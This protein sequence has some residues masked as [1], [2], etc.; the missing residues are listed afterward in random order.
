[1]TLLSVSFFAGCHSHTRDD[2]AATYEKARGDFLHGN[3]DVARQEAHKAQRDFPAGDWTSRFRLLEAEILTYQG[4]RPDVIAL[5][6]CDRAAYPAAGDTAI[7]RKVLCAQAHAGLGKGLQADQE[8]HDAHSLSDTTHSALIG[9]VLQT[10]AKVQLSRDHVHEA[11]DLYQQSLAAA[12]EQGNSFLEASDLLN[13]GYVAL[14]AEHY[15]EAVTLLNKAASFAASVQA[16]L[17]SEASLGN[18]GVAFFHLGDFEKALANF[19]QAEEEAKK[20]GTTSA[21]V[22]WLWDAGT[23]HYRLGNLEEAK[24][25]YEQSL[26]A[27]QAIDNLEEIA[28]INT[29]LALLLY[30]QGQF[31]AAKAHS[32][33]AIRAAR[34]SG[35]KSAEVEPRFVQAQ[36]F[37]ARQPNSPDAE[38]ALMALDHDAADTPSLQWE[39]ENAIG[40]LYMARHQLQPAELWYRKSIDIFESQREALNDEELRLP[41]FA[42]GDALYR[43]YADFLIASQEPDAALQFLDFGRAR[44]LE[45]GLDPAKKDTAKGEKSDSWKEAINPQSIARRLNATILFYSLG[46][47]K[48]RLWAVTGNATR[49]FTLPGQEEIDAH[50]KRYQK[51][52]LRSSDPLREANEDGRAL[53][54]ILVAPAA[55]AIRQGSRVFVIPDGSLNTLNFETLLAPGTDGFHYW[56]E[57]VTVTNANSI[58]LLS[59]SDPNSRVSDN[60]SLLLIGNPVSPSADYENLPNAS[61]EISDIENHFPRDR[62]TV[63]TQAQAVPSAY[64]ASK[65]GRFS[66]IHFVAHGTA[67]RLSPLDSA[68]VLTAT[69]TRPD[70]FK[71]YARD[72]VHQPLQAKLVTISACYGSGQRAYAGEGLVGLSWAFLRAGSHNVIGALWAVN[73]SSTPL[74]MD[75]LYSGLEAGSRPDVALRAAK[76]S[77]IHSEGVYR[78]P[79]YW[80]AFQLY[81]GT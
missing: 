25:C 27:A 55:S 7:K 20:I 15:D 23:A 48:S 5:L 38:R 35:D 67:S 19:E 32:E 73:D 56:I 2:P 42:N 66:Y 16:T 78:K 6:D 47:D 22:D 60:N 81:A 10:E 3:L 74:L 21:Q 43:D 62:R 61:A 31:D 51:A 46:P 13:L 53:Y 18:L 49:L 44:T 41:F 40:D 52:I 1:M 36:L 54:D 59:H 39:I 58:R 28:G 71:L 63:L 65:P 12:Q 64:A 77:L 79:L 68:V 80:A 33:A 29:E 4:R 50:V 11:A 14:D 57:D 70:D 76:L 8:L 17:V 9:E 69:P 26:M 34:Q 37:A 72:I 75:K 45:E 30:Q 24:K